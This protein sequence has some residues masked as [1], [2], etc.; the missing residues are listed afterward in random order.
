MDENNMFPNFSSRLEPSPD[1]A[2]SGSEVEWLRSLLQ[3]Y[4]GSKWGNSE[5]RGLDTKFAEDTYVPTR[6][7]T[8]LDEDIRSRA[9]RLVILCGNAGDG[10]T[11]LLQHLAERLGLGKH[12]SAGRIFEGKLNDGLTVRINLDGSA[13]WQGRSSD[14]ILT[15]FLEPFQNGLPDGDIVHLLAINDGRLLEWIEF[16]EKEREETLLTRELYAYLQEEDIPH[17]PHIRFITLNQRS[18]V[19]NVDDKRGHISTDFLDDL[20]NHLYGGDRAAEI[21]QP[22]LNCSA[23]EK[24]EVYRAARIFGPDGLP[25]PA[26][27]R[28]QTRARERLFEALQA[29]HLK[30]VIHLTMRELRSTL[31]YILFGVHFCT[32]YAHPEQGERILPY[33]DRAFAADSPRRQGE[34]LKEMSFFDPAI[35]THPKIDRH[36][37][38]KS[39]DDDTVTP[40]HYP[41]LPLA[42]ARRRAYFEWSE[43][44]L[45][46]LTGDANALGLFGG[47]NLSLFKTLPLADEKQLA[48]ILDRLCK[49]ISRLEDLPPIA[50]TFE[51]AAPLR[52][53]QRT[54]TE[55]YFWVEKPLSSFRLKPDLPTPTPGLERLHHQAY[56]LF[57]YRDGK[58]ERLIMGAD[59]FNLLLELGDGYQLGD[60]STDDTFSKLFIFVQRLVREDE[61]D[62]RAWNPMCEDAIYRIHSVSKG[63]EEGRKQVV[64]LSVIPQEEKDAIQQ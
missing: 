59:L 52:L 54:P 7:E 45:E 38:S 27:K 33:W 15:E 5:T 3:S 6:L 57:R 62:I 58:E 29:I 31:V 23:R 21:W 4:P 13:S 47:K 1:D 44:D 16:I 10:K 9:V 11:A 43:E 35:D 17:D 22:C 53:P 19:G 56:L 12:Q 41:D 51:N 28:V 40:P 24:C 18:L 61:R 46:N 63:E 32:D 36:L 50:H 39:N 2:R 30:G 37:L 20:V 55:T 48:D 60:V 49:G 8:K 34:A 14:E 64:T 26:D 25:D 42:S